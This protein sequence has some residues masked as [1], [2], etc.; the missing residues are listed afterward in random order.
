MDG[1]G[2]IPSAWK[3]LYNIHIIP[4]NIHFGQ[5]MFLQGVDI[6]DS[7]FYKAAAT[8]SEVPKTSQPTPQQFIQF[9]EKIAKVGDTILS[10]HVTSKLSGT[11][12]SAVIAARELAGRIKVIPFDSGSGSAVM[13]FMCREASQMIHRGVHIEEILKRLDFIRKQNRI[14]LTLDTLEYA[15]KSG[16]VK[17]LQAALASMLQI[18]PII[19]LHDGF[20]NMA[21]RVRTRQRSLDE[22][23]TKLAAEMAGHLS[24]VGVVH[25][26]SPQIAE[27]L[28]EKVKALMNCAEVVITD[29]SIGI[30]ANLG[31]GTVGVVAYP[32][33]N[34]DQLKSGGNIA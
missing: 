7:E 34:T 2:D 8:S 9:Y 5:R 22:I 27:L 21:D 13:G 14:V 4:I 12:A 19:E 20:L 6:S 11:Y 26:Q 24:V 29:L 3:K 15:R 23:V 18:K 33:E 25:S 16:R 28:S 31:P 1:A 10:V 17:A 32:V 30:A